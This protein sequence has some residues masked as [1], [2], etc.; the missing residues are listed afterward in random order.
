MP[1]FGV[2]VAKL[3]KQITGYKIDNGTS[4]IVFSGEFSRG[5]QAAGVSTAKVNKDYV[6]A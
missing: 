5:S 4:L 3:G 2:E 6:V 1:N